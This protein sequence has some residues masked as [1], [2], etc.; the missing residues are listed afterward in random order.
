LCGS[1]GD[2]SCAGQ[3][4]LANHDGGRQIPQWYS[5]MLE[6]SGTPKLGAQL[7]FRVRAIPGE[8]RCSRLAQRTRDSMRSLQPGGVPRPLRNQ[9]RNVSSSRLNSKGFSIMSAWPASGFVT[10]R[11]APGR[12]ERVFRRSR[13]MPMRNRAQSRGSSVPPV[14]CGEDPES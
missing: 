8:R 7:N 4:P 5:A 2:Y 13:D 1:K 10:N 6:A 11:A 3:G 12:P 9:T 14:R